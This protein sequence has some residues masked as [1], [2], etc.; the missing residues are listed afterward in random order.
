MFNKVT[1]TC[2]PCVLALDG[3]DEFRSI[4]HSQRQ[5]IDDLKTAV[6]ATRCRILITSRDEFDIELGLRSSIAGTADC[7]V[8][9]CKVSTEVVKG[10]IALVSQS[11]VG[12]RLPKQGNSLRQDLAAKMAE[13]C[14]GQFLWLKLQEGQLRDSKSRKALWSIVEAMPKGLHSSYGRSWTVIQGLEEPDR[15]R[16]V[17][18]LPWLTFAYRPLTVNELAE[19]LIVNL[20]SDTQAFSEDDLPQDTDDEYIDNEIKNLCGSLLEIRDEDRPSRERT[21]HLVHASVTDF[22]IEQLPVWPLV[23]S[24]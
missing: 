7:L 17:G 20:D 12:K 15:H 3:L 8:L 2:G 23:T 4:D 21:V 16:A 9:E 5:F 13:R 1:R 18:I 6:Q 14:E 24:L 10:D 19:A 11:I 22:L